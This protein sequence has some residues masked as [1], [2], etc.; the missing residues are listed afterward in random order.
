MLRVGS[1]ELVNENLSR[2][3]EETVAFDDIADR[4]LR[5]V[6]E[7]HGP[8]VRGE[9]IGSFGPL[10]GEVATPLAMVLTEL[11]QNGA[12]HAYGTAGGRLSVAVNRIRDRV[13]LR[14]VD[15]GAGLPA[16]FDAGQSLGLS[17]VT[18][19]V[20][21]ELGGTLTFAS[22]PGRGTTVTIELSL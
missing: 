7:V 11:I 2:S 5:T 21:S 4:L 18:T 17:I 10:P 14:V 9:R 8:Q 1:I 20:E 6:L 15:D 3:F 12:E 19:L 22:R 16:D 13:R